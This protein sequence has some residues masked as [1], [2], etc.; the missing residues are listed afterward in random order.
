MGCLLS[1]GG[2]GEV[3]RARVNQL[4]GQSICSGLLPDIERACAAAGWDDALWPERSVGIHFIISCVNSS[5]E[6]L[7]DIW[8]A[9]AN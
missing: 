9:A 3:L 4:A 6:S 7:C 5:K 8:D 2:W 1:M